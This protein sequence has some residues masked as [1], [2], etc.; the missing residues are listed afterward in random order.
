MVGEDS[1]FLDG[2][3]FGSFG[4]CARDGGVCGIVFGLV[5][6]WLKLEMN[7]DE[8]VLIVRLIGQAIFSGVIFIFIV[9]RLRNTCFIL[10]DAWV[11]YKIEP[12]YISLA[13]ILG[14]LVMSISALFVKAITG[15]V[16]PPPLHPIRF[17]IGFVILLEI[18]IDAFIVGVVEEIFFRGLI[19]QALRKYHNAI[20]AIL[21]STII[22]VLFHGEIIFFPPR[23]NFLF[24]CLEF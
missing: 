3:V 9:S 4:H 6:Y 11:S 20:P 13:F 7:F 17:N 21:I 12:A 16:A 22:F 10:K 24:Q 8:Q 14:V 15:E 1:G 18:L 23:E 5:N 2:R 19:F